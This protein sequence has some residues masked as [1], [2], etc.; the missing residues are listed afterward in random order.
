M[1][2]ATVERVREAYR[3]TR[4]GNP[5]DLLDYFT[6]DA[7][8]E[9]AEG[10][11]WQP[12]EGGDQVAKTLLWRS[13]VHRLRATEFVDVGNQVVVGVMGRRLSRLGAPWWAWK[14]FQVFTVRDGRISKIQDYPRRQDAFA[15]VGLRV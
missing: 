5:F 11:T 1:A 12:C 8:W 15:A 4:R 14:V 3:L 10:T 6:P 13:A 7:V 9:G 2:E